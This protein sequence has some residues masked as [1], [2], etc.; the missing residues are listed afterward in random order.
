LI[1]IIRILPFIISFIVS[2]LAKSIVSLIF[3]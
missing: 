1:G 3:D 2:R